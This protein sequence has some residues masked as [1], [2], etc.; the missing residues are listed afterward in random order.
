[1]FFFFFIYFQFIFFFFFLRNLCF[2]V[3]DKVRFLESYTFRV[4]TLSAFFS[5]VSRVIIDSSPVRW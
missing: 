5:A 3:E 1:M 2:V 4:R